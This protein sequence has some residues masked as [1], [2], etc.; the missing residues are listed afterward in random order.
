MFNKFKRYFYWGGYALLFLILGWGGLRIFHWVSPPTPEVYKVAIDSTWYPLSLYGKDSAF[1]AFSIDLLFAIA[2]REK[3]KV[4]VI[5]SGP[6]RLIELLED[7]K[8]HAVFSSIRPDAEKEAEFLFSEPYYRFGAVLIFR[9]ED[10]F[11]TLKDLPKKRIAVK[12]NSPILYR[13]QLD[14]NAEVVPFDSPIAALDQLTRNEVD[15]VIMDQLLA[16]LYVSGFYTSKLK[17][18]TLPL[19][20]DGLRLVTCKGDIQE[21]LI[22]SFN[23]GLLKIKEDG[24]YVQLLKQW[25]LYDPGLIEGA[26]QQ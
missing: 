19:T 9:R 20:T 21:E 16:Y 6:K 15:G 7:E 10:P 14:P 12:R 8:V 24:V 22:T 11:T 13:I 23:A 2:K 25:D 26:A 1:T 4:E 5:R 3:I 18:V 17:V